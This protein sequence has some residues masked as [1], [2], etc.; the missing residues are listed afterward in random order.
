[1][2]IKYRLKYS[3]KMD[4]LLAPYIGKKLVIS[5]EEFREF[6]NVPNIKTSSALVQKII[7]T[8]KR[9]FDE[10]EQI[11]FNFEVAKKFKKTQFFIFYPYN[12]E[13]NF[14]LSSIQDKFKI[15]P[16][17]E[18]YIE[19][20]KNLS[21]EEISTPVIAQEEKIIPTEPEEI[22]E[23]KVKYEFENFTNFKVPD[24]DNFNTDDIQSGLER[25]RKMRQNGG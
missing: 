21:F 13:P 23:E 24:Y 11:N 18:K 19:P 5:V 1:M 9:E 20:T 10:L 4:E 2:K 14:F 7:E 25:I 3:G 6:F 17:K 15:E 8:C 16:E 22:E 12:N